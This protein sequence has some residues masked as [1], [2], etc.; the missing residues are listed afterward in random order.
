[1]KIERL[2]QANKTIEFVK[3]KIMVLLMEEAQ[4][5]DSGEE[6]DLH[7]SFSIG[8]LIS[9]GCILATVDAPDDLVDTHAKMFPAAVEIARKSRTDTNIIN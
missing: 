3:E 6:I 8:C 9:A 2:Q 5:L 1:M 4:G 7:Y